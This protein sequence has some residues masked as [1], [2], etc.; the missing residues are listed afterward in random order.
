MTEKLKTTPQEIHAYLDG[1]LS[2]Q[3]R[4][5]FEEALK[6]DPAL[7]H[8][9]CELRKIKQQ[10]LEHYQKVPVP[11]RPTF[12]CQGSNRTYWAAAASVALVVALG[13]FALPYSPADSG[14]QGVS[15]VQNE[16][17]DSRILLHIDSNQ[18]EKTQALLQK[19]STLLAENKAQEGVPPMQ[20]E[21]VANDHG[22]ELFEQDNQS[23]EAIISLLAQYDNLKLIACQRALERRAAKGE[24]AKLIDGVESDKTAIDEI[25]NRMQTGWK[26]YKF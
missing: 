17:T 18:P 12:E 26:Y 24:P 20:I 11:P 15:V 7:R 9:V 22:I 13:V 3:E 5:R 23:R 6:L 25:V 16:A 14:M 1:E 2:L 10:M 4:Q 21:I 8:E 19:A